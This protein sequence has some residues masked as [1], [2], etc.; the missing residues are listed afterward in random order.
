MKTQHALYIDAKMNR[1]EIV[2]LL[3]AKASIREQLMLE[4]LA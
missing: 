4:F 2:Q 1:Q 3:L